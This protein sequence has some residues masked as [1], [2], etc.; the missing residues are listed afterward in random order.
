M[1]VAATIA[2][3]ERDAADRF[4]AAPTGDFSLREFKA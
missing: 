1:E 2:R 4:T 3:G